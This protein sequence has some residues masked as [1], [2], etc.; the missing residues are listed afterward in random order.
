MWKTIFCWCTQ[1]QISCL[2]KERSYKP[3]QSAY[4]KNSQFYLQGSSGWEWIQIKVRVL[5]SPWVLSAANQFY[6]YHLSQ[7]LRLFLFYT[8][9]VCSYKAETVDWVK[10]QTWGCVFYH[11]PPPNLHPS[12]ST[13]LLLNLSLSC[14]V[15]GYL[16]TK[17]TQCRYVV[18]GFFLLALQLHVVGYLFVSC[19]F[20]L[21]F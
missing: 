21:L 7:D 11:T 9:G 18:C 4:G 12:P 16:P 13:L 1:R 3:F 5:P 2:P 19:A 17:D 20:I 10:L 6:S 14:G 8:Q 15:F